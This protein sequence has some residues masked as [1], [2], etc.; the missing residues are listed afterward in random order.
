MSMQVQW[1]RVFTIAFGA[2][3]WA[4]TVALLEVWVAFLAFRIAGGAK[5]DMSGMAVTGCCF[6]AFP[7]IALAAVPI[8]SSASEKVMPGDQRRV[9]DSRAA[10]TPPRPPPPRPKPPDGS[11]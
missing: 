8:A 3:I 2:L 10:G 11:P 5:D 4:A 6:L 9:F 7:L 1:R